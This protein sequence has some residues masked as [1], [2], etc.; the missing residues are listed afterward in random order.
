[1]NI[2]NMR[3]ILTLFILTIFLLPVFGQRQK[4]VHATGSAVG[5]HTES[6]YEEALFKAKKDALLQAG[7]TESVTSF[8]TLHVG[9]QTEMSGILSDELSLIELDGR[10]RLV[11]EPEVTRN[12]VNDLVE[13]RVSIVAEVLMEDKKSDPE[14]SFRADG[15]KELYHNETPIEFSIL[16][17]K[18][19]YL[20][21]FWFDASP[22][23]A[24]SGDLIYP[25]PDFFR[26]IMLKKGTRY[27]FPPT[28]NEF[29]LNGEIEF[30]A[31]KLHDSPL[32][33]NLIL[34]VLLKRSIPF[35]ESVDYQ[36]VYRW[37]L[38]IPADERC[39]KWIKFD[40]TK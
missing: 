35:T 3:K 11:R 37:L 36:T 38:N 25:N 2:T 16:P 20:R 5:K 33:P 34:I 31:D 8:T 13:A 19:G 30:T 23:Q 39:Y 10:V 26:D 24:H 1:M 40:I 6:T 29:N 17:F 12:M 14:F 28:T 7:F 27:A 22:K 9:A 15:F 18:D 4:T 21:V 32:E